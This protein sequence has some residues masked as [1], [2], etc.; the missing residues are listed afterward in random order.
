MDFAIAQLALLFLPG[1]IWANLDAK[2]GAGRRPSQ[3]TMLLRAFVFGIAT[4]AALSAIYWLCGSTFYYGQYAGS[5]SDINVLDMRGE[6]ALSV[7]LSVVMAIIWLY[8]VRFRVL[9]HILHWIGATARYG[10]EDVWSF[11]LNS[12]DAFVEY[13]HLHDRETGYV[14]CG[15]VN[16]YSETEDY[17][18]LLLNDA[19]VLDEYGKEVSTAPH[20]YL[21]R[22][23]DH[24]WIDFPYDERGHDVDEA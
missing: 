7:P 12:S 10:D 21:S 9:M 20:L 1:I 5:P 14:Y 16:T 24:I 4:Y 19:I 13:V 6:I 3:F 8:A 23:K 17:R 2:Y 22:P 15:W 18:E 11:T